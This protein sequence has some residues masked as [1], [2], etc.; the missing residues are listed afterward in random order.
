MR[1]HKKNDNDLASRLGQL[2]IVTVIINMNS[3]NS[4]LYD[5]ATIDRT[6]L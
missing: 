2:E 6:H 3:I 4:S 5:L 1:L